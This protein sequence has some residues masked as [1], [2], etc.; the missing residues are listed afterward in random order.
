M[1]AE[2]LEELVYGILDCPTIESVHSLNYW[3]SVV[4]EDVPAGEDLQ[5]PLEPVSGCYKAIKL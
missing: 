1:W 4:C 5:K 2:L 3:N